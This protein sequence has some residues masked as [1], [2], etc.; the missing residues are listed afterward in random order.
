MLD[1]AN[2][3]LTLIVE[4]IDAIESYIG[5]MD[6][7]AFV[8]SRLT[9]DAVAMNFQVIGEAARHLTEI[10]R[11]ETPEIPWPKIVGLRHRISHDYRTVNFGLVWDIAHSEFDPLKVAARRMLTARGETSA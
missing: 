6:R 2:L 3:H 4:S 10:E 11:A 8:A 5:D 7:A 9:R 1:R